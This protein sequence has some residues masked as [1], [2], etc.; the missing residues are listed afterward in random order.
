ME[1][2]IDLELLTSFK[3]RVIESAT[4]R[5]TQVLDR[6]LKRMAPSGTR[7]E[8]WLHGAL[9]FLRRLAGKVD[10]A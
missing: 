4:W 8:R 6:G 5:L 9:A 10:E 7:R 2:A 3:A 1:Q